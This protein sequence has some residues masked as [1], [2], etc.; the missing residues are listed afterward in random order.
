MAKRDRTG[1]SNASVVVAAFVLGPCQHAGHAG[2]D[3]D[4]WGPQHVDCDGVCTLK[5]GVAVRCTCPCHTQPDSPEAHA[6]V[7]AAALYREGRAEERW[8]RMRNS[9]GEGVLG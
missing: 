5:P 6:R 8:Q 9:G 4:W 2:T 7:A 1:G 3:T